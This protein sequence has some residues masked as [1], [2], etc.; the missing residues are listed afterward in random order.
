MLAALREEEVNVGSSDWALYTVNCSSY[1]R[2]ARISVVNRPTQCATSGASMLMF[3]SRETFSGGLV[4][5]KQK[6]KPGQKNE[7]SSGTQLCAHRGN[8]LG[9]LGDR[10]TRALEIKTALCERIHVI[11]YH[12]TIVHNLQRLPNL[13]RWTESNKQKVVCQLP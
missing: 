1:V 10:G 12:H 4:R 13:N 2:R 9:Q 11:L 7:W 3:L 5:V 6:E 8:D